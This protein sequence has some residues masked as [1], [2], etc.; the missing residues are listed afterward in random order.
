MQVEHHT[1][2]AKAAWATGER[3]D[4]VVLEQAAEEA[5]KEAILIAKAAE[6]SWQE[7]CDTE[8]EGN[9]LLLAVQVRSLCCGFFAVRR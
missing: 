4:A 8:A 5:Q 1:D 3:E 2:L 6:V 9:R 7:A